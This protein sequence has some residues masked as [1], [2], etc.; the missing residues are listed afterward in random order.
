MRAHLRRGSLARA[1]LRERQ[2][3]RKPPWPAN[4]DASAA[5]ATR[6]KYVGASESADFRA[7]ESIIHPDATFRMPPDFGVGRRP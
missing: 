6:K 7:F 5:N 2:P 4:V 3:R 1:R